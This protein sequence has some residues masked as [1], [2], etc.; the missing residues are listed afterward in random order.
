MNV[1]DPGVFARYFEAVHGHQPFPWQARLASR[2]LAEGRWPPLLDLPTGTG[3]TSAI[4]VALFAL[5]HRPDVF[6]RRIVLVVDRRVV[7]D[8]GA[9][10]ARRIQTALSTARD[11]AAGSVASALRALFDGEEDDPP[12]IVSVLR[13]GMPRDE[14]WTQRPDQPVVALSTVDQVGS[15]LLFRGYGVSPRMAPVHAG[16]LGNDTLLLLDEVHLSTAFA[17]TL[18]A[19][20]GRWRRWHV[21][22]SGAALPDR[23]AAV[24]MSATPS[25]GE[26]SDVSPF[27]LDDDDLAHPVLAKRIGA[28]KL[29]RLDTV[30]VTGDE[31]GRAQQLAGA[32]ASAAREAVDA[33]ARA[34]AVVVNRVDTARRVHALLHDAAKGRYDV[35]L[36]TGR[37]RPLDRVEIMGDAA[38]ASSLAGRVIAGRSRSGQST[39]VVAVATQC[40]EAGADFDF[41]AIVSECASLD[42]LRQRFGR[43]DRRGELGETRSTILVRHDQAAGSADDPV[44]GEAL[45]ATWSWLDG[46]ARAAGPDGLVDMGIAGF[47][48]LP[49]DPGEIGQLCSAIVHAPILLPAHVDAW[50]Q[51]NPRP[52]PEPDVS[53]WLHG[54]ER[55]VP[56]VRI[57]W[58]ADID[59]Q[60]LNRRAAGAEEE[61]RRELAAD[62]QPQLA[63]CPPSSLESVSVPLPA[64]RAW[65][66]RGGLETFGDVEGAREIEADPRR[67]EPTESPARL[68]VRAR[69]DGAEV[70]D[71]DEV[72]PDDTVVVPSSYGGIGHGSW[73]P[74]STEFVTDIGD[75]AQLVHRGRP[76]LRLVPEVLAGPAARRRPDAGTAEAST[77]AGGCPVELAR[78]VPRVPDGDDSDFDPG[79]AAVAWVEDARTAAGAR[80]AAVLRAIGGRL[81]PR[82]VP[83]AG[84]WLALVGRRRVDPR[85]V[86]AL[87]EDLTAEFVSE[88]D[89]SSSFVGLPVTL[90]DH[91]SDVREQTR[92]FAVHAGLGEAVAFDLALAAS[93]HDVGKADRRFQQMLAGGSEV[94]LALQREPLAKS[95]GDAR[96]LVSR[97][98]ARVRAG[99]PRG[100]RHELLSVAMI[101]RT[102]GALDGARDRDLVLHLV[103][104]HHGWCRPFAPARDHGPHLD[105][106]LE[107][108]GL[109]L[110]GDAAHGLARL[111]SGVADRFF[112][113]VERYGWWGLAWLEAIVRLADHR[114]SEAADD[115]M[116]RDT[117]A[118]RI[119]EGDGPRIARE[120]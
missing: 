84:G 81:Q 58:R 56:E 74:Q 4:D 89:D 97:E 77:D 109:V 12:F 11:G 5:A 92:R 41:D 15:R 37:M 87:P 98:L 59:E 76:V 10:H 51:T 66:A 67:R 14:A 54:P 45:A 31:A 80:L 43:V 79:A 64:F 60:R 40:I 24:R 96:D 119:R 8:Q 19:L 112:D 17:E 62:L 101:E 32:C 82:V 29:A 35:A 108:D 50:A 52:E 70:V 48:P 115:P 46:R 34:V 107:L 2:V 114:A 103:G 47:P 73:N 20:D 33:G 55:G 6:P 61:G 13:G 22:Q 78:A 86:L 90:R 110:R 120:A 3:K 28:R 18:Q 75:W 91:L 118:S 7:V 117:S 69:R 94:R 42:A 57:V 72:R 83:I 9:E 105:V 111:D 26:P 93:L 27:R 113:L 38:D 30:R 99:Y 44:Y 21:G 39:P 95:A 68:C 49:E 65:L 53:L 25:G 36:L 104:S 100:Y 106:G 1:P 23:W 102:P 63:V 88:D 71:P 16:L 85:S 116:V